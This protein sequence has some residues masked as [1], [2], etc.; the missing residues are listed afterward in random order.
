[1]TPRNPPA[2]SAMPPTGQMLI[3]QTEDGR[4]KIEAR[5]QDETLWLTQSQMAELFQTTQQNI[6]LH[7]GNVFEEG[8]LV[9]SATHKDFL[10]VRA[11]G[12]RQVSRQVAQ[13]PPPTKA[14]AARKPR[15]AKKTKKP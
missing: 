2:A 6:S 4:I 7:V 9:E 3:Y 1:M 13:L 14:S 15:T 8:E 5:L 12:A 10:L 11:E